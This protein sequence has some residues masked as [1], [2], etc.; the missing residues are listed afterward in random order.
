MR[1]RVTLNSRPTS[2]SVR[3]RPSSRPNR[4]CSTRDADEL[5]DR[6]HHVDRDADRPRLVR[7][8]AGDRLTDPPRRVRRELVSL[9]VVELLDRTDEADVPF[10]DQVE[11]AHAAADVLLRDRHDE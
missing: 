8:G 7:D 10:L 1:S 4:S 6:L 5:V 2:S 11:E 3:V 9:A